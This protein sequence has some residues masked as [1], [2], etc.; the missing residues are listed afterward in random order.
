MQVRGKRSKNWMVAGPGQA[1]AALRA[2][3]LARGLGSIQ[4]A[5]PTSPLLSSCLDPIAPVGYQALDEHVK[6]LLVKRC[7]PPAC[8]P[9]SGKAW[10][11]RRRTG[12]AIPLVPGAIARGV[13]LE[14]IQALVGHR[15]PDSAFKRSHRRLRSRTRIF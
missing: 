13:P 6:D 2:Y 4:E 3:L 12:C 1:L 8:R 5:P 14:V 9:T 11:G 10:P 7:G 15:A